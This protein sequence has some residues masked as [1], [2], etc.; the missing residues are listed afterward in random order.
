MPWTII[1]TTVRTTTSVSLTARHHRSSHH[2]SVRWH[3]SGNAAPG[4]PRCE[5]TAGTRRDGCRSSTWRSRCQSR[6]PAPRTRLRPGRPPA[7]AAGPG[8]VHV[9]G[10]YTMSEHHDTPRWPEAYYIAKPV[11]TPDVSAVLEQLGGDTHF[12]GPKAD[13]CRPTVTIDGHGQ[14]TRMP[15][16][17]MRVSGG[18]SEFHRQT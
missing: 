6:R 11:L 15:A 13:A 14:L 7:Q 3:P 5:G 1:K 8:A 4:C 18:G 16:L 2:V 17:V 10:C 12:S 9:L